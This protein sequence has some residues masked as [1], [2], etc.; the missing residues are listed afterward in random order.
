MH[1]YV[2]SSNCFGLA[3]HAIH[4]WSS[5]FQECYGYI[6]SVAPDDKVASD[7]SASSPSLCRWVN[8]PDSKILTAITKLFE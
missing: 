4:I 3:V 7:I 8:R 1:I 2:S 6:E 5:K